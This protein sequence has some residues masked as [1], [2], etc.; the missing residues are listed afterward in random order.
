LLV[1][2]SGKLLSK[3]LP[4]IYFDSSVIID[5]WLA[6]SLEFSPPDDEVTR[7]ITANER[8]DFEVIRK[9]LKTEK[10]VNEM[11]EIRKIL[12]FDNP[13]LQAVISPL[14]VLELMEWQAEIGFKDTV[15]E[16]VSMRF[17]QKKSKK[18]IG[19]YLKRLIKLREDEQKLIKDKHQE[20]STGLEMIMENTW[21]SRATLDHSGLV[22]LV[23]VPITNLNLTLN[24]IWAEPSAFAY[25]QLGL[26][27][28][29]HI[30]LCRHFGC[31]YLASFDTDFMRVSDIVEKEWDIKVI[32]DPEQVLSLFQQK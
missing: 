12:H 23:Q 19:D 17:V 21:L 32:S 2:E 11:I 27:D 30:V 7:I 9:L 3:F 20:G 5:Y 15:A 22:G 29:M 13:P 18:E 8:R 4:A 14:S 25:L 1:D 24:D 26:A 6:D 16:A 28:I 31:T 10:R